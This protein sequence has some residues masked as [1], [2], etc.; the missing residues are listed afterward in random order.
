FRNCY[1]RRKAGHVPK[2]RTCSAR[3][4][5]ELEPLE[6]RFMP[7]VAQ[8]PIPMAASEPMGIARGPDGNLWFAEL[9]AI[10][11]ITPAGAA[12]ALTQGLAP[13]RDPV[14]ITAGA[15]GNLWFTE[16]GTD[17][18]GRITTAGA[19]TEFS[20]SNTGGRQLFVEGITAGPDGNI[21]FTEQ[22]G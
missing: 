15:D 1:Q 17:R 19:I 18:I 12:P 13:D 9:H 22:A 6:D 2:K 8:F 11:R 5:L 3:S 10:G 4:R 7:A 20:I 16:G 21:W 14:D